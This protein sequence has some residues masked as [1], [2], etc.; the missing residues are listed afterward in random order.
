M[1]YG[2]HTYIDIIPRNPVTKTVPEPNNAPV[3]MCCISSDKGPEDF[4]TVYGSS[5]FNLYGDNISFEKHGQPLLQAANIINNGGAILVKRVVA[6]DATLANT[7]IWAVLKSG[8]VHKTNDDG[9]KLYIDANTGEEVTSATSVV[10]GVGDA[11]SKTV[12]NTPVMITDNQVHFETTSYSNI[13]NIGQVKAIVENAA[14]DAVKKVIVNDAN[15]S[16]LGSA[17]IALSN[18]E[19]IAELSKVFGNVSSYANK[20]VI[21]VKFTDNTLVLATAKD[22]MPYT[23]ADKGFEEE[24]KNGNFVAFRVTLPEDRD[25]EGMQISLNGNNNGPWG[26][27][28]L[29]DGK[30]LDMLVNIARLDT[31]V[32]TFEWANGETTTF[33]VDYR[34]I[35]KTKVDGSTT[36]PIEIEVGADDTYV[37]KFPIF[38]FTDKGRGLSN[39][40]IRISPNGRVS[41]GLQYMLYQVQILEG[42]KILENLNFCSDYLVIRKGENMSLQT[43]ITTYSSQV[44]ACIFTKYQDMFINTVA[45]S[46]GVTGADI[47]NLDYLFGTD[48]SGKYSIDN[49]LTSTGKKDNTT[50][51]HYDIEGGINMSSVFGVSL[52]NGSNGKFGTHPWGTD[53]YFQA[54]EDFWT[55]KDGSGVIF[56]VDAIKPWAIIDAN[57]PIQIKKA[58]ERLVK[59]REDCFFF[60]DLGLGLKTRDDIYY[61]ELDNDSDGVIEEIGID[62]KDGMFCGSYHNSLDVSDPYTRRQITVTFSYELSQLLPHHFKNGVYRPVCGQ[63]YGMTVNDAIEGTINYIPR[64]KPGI[65]EKEDLDDNRINYITQQDNVLV[66]D[67][68]WTAVTNTATEFKYIHNVL[69][70]QSVIRAVRRRCPKIRYSFLTA[71]DLTNYKKAVQDVL[72]EFAGIFDTLEFEYIDDKTMVQNKVFYAAIR[73]SFKEFIRSEYFKIYE[74]ENTSTIK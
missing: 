49:K 54:V 8:K 26:P 63:M 65:N 60:R 20:N 3:F 33:T 48:R 70:V 19:S 17:P 62:E 15:Q 31:S 36:T 53:A 1:G 64:T 24:N 52:D 43:V 6:D 11:P 59:F 42:T 58:I 40:R 22:A 74:I 44:E 7:V 28:V 12:N 46:I 5:F 27:E 55:D 29:T 34:A 67:S 25:T 18:A 51:L 61:A 39:K 2:P 72:D 57:Y 10:P 9:E 4:R 68:D 47:G 41:K 32:V 56:D 71:E 21:P 73:V 30:Y 23:T 45:K 13:S 66:L 69:A 35:A 37:Q 16:T 50:S 38:A 14:V